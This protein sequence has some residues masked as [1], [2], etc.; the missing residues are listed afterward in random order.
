MLNRGR[1]LWEIG[2]GSGRGVRSFAVVT[3]DLS[4]VRRVPLLPLL[5][6]GRCK[7][8]KVDGDE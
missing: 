4:V 2:I 1:A 6:F 5:V 3:D 8:K 7:S